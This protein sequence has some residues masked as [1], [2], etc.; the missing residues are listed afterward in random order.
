MKLLTS[1]CLLLISFISLPAQAAEKV[2]GMAM[3]GDLKYGPDF[4]HFEYV[5]PNA[6]K[7]G[8]L[9][10]HSIGTFDNLNGFIMKGVAAGNLSLLYDTLLS[11]SEDEPFSEYG[12]LAESVERAD[13]NSYIRFNLHP[14]AKFH[15]GKAVTPEDVIWTFNTLLEK[16]LPFYRAYYGAVESVEKTGEQQVTFT[17]KDKTNKELPL[18]LGQLPVL[19]KHYWDGKDFASTTLEAPLGSGPY[20]I[21]AVDAGKRIVYERVTDY[22]GKDLPVNKGRYNFDTIEL[23]YY[24]DA[25]VAV[26]ALLAGEYDYRLENIAK[27]WATTYKDAQAVKD[28]RIVLKEIEHSRPAGMQAF[29]LN[30]RRPIFADIAIRKAVNL[31]FDFEWANRQFAYGSYT[32]TDSYFE[33]S[34]LASSDLPEGEELAI[35]EE[36]KDQ[37]PPA[38]FT[39]EFIVPKTKGDGNNRKQLREAMHILDEA[40]YKTGPDGLRIDPK[41]GQP[42]TFEIIEHQPAFERWTLPLI[43]NLKKIGIKATFRIV[44]TAQYQNR[45]LTHDYDMTVHTFPQSLSPGNEQIEYWHSS[46]AD[47]EGSRNWLGI[48]SPVVDDLVMKIVNAESREDLV[49][50]TRALDRVL[51]WGYYVIPQWHLNK[52]RLAYNS[53]IAMP[54]TMA[55]YASD[56]TSTWWVK[57]DE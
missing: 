44:D 37:L 36:Y 52:F 54:E 48:K 18:I 40:G 12:L 1:L 20:K 39:E 27:T 21:K 2:H 25:T 42:L 49:A 47:V 50:Y 23:D 13:D 51:K 57:A 26:E 10:E 14:S 30:Q 6:P 3:H 8:T 19:P 28:G 41:T 15:D 5:N 33:N 31:A 38:L 35:L 4:T 24:R 55:P 43:Q 7:G 56:L 32:R 53:K 45:V 34:E 16:G 22:W 11:A 46:K 9:K 17:F 29:A